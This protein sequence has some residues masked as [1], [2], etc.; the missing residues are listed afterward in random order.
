M[1][2]GISPAVHTRKKTRFS[3]ADEARALLLAADSVRYM[4]EL[5]PVIF[6]GKVIGSVYGKDGNAWISPHDFSGFPGGYYD[7]KASFNAGRSFQAV[8]NINGSAGA[9]ANRWSDLWPCQ[10]AQGA[11]N[12]Y[13]GTASTARQFT[14]VSSGAIPHGGNVTPAVKVLAG[15]HLLSTGSS[16]PG[17]AFMLYDRVL[18]YDENPITA[19]L[20]TMTNTLTAQRWVGS[21]LPALRICMT[22]GKTVTGATVSDLSS[23]IYAND[24]IVGSRTMPTTR[25]III[26]GTSTPSA[27]QPA[28]LIAFDT[29]NGEYGP[30]L[31]LQATDIGVSSITSYQCTANN[32]G[33]I[34]FVL[35]RPLCIMVAQPT[36]IASLIDGVT[37]RFLMRRIYDGACLGFLVRPPNQ[38]GDAG[39]YSGRLSMVWQ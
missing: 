16:T 13:S 23:L 25:T 33:T 38:A 10:L 12:A 7:V 19:T 35:M 17:C 30:F 29:S 5:L 1:L 37:E 15:Y 27:T 39:T 3:L 4:D 2:A 20:T 24:A 18:S 28:D 22:A 11:A 32:T 31:P 9:N 26:A 8:Y 21:G 6:G 14:D 34:T 36:G